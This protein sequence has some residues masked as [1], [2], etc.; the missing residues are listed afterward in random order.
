M[1]YTVFHTDIYI[2]EYAND[3]SNNTFNAYHA[4]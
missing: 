1:K 3:S 4:E 2:H